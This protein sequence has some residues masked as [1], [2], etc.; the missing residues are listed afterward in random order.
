MNRSLSRI[1]RLIPLSLALLFTALW[2]TSYRDTRFIGWSDNRQ[3]FGLLSMSGLLRLERATYPADK[4]GW[5]RNNYPSPRDGL[6]SEVEARDRQGPLLLRRLGLTYSHIDYNSDGKN[7]RYS[8]Y[9]PHWLILLL[10]LAIPTLE[11]KRLLYRP[12]PPGHCQKCGYDLRATPDRCPEC[13]TLVARP[14]RP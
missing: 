10:L 14:S 6:W 1:L 3:W 13:G 2:L 12:P 5:M 4:I 7:R 9:L 11:L 8:I